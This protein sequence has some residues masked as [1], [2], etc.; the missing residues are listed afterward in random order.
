MMQ[1]DGLKRTI[2]GRCKVLHVNINIML[3]P[4]GLTAIH[5]AAERGLLECLRYTMLF[6]TN[7]CAGKNIDDNV[8]HAKENI[9]IHVLR[10][11]LHTY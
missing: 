10:I 8:K 11:V 2:F 3:Q 9:C 1:V 4:S 6:S 7:G 5:M